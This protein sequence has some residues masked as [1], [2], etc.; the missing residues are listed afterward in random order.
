MRPVGPCVE[1]LQTKAGPILFQF[2][3]LSMSEVGG[4]QRFAERLHTFLD[5]LP[6]GPLYA[7]ELRNRE[8]FT[9]AYVEAL[10][11]AGAVHC[12]SVHPT[13]PPVGEQYHLA[14]AATSAALVVRWMLHPG[15]RYE[16]A[17]RRYE[18]F[19]QLVDEDPASRAA[20]AQLCLELASNTRPAVVIAN[21]KAEGSSPLT[22]QKL[23]ESLTRSL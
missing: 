11:S 13:M 6:R 16:A 1:G 17:R 21:N 9:P 20:I 15:Q 22:I 18:P 2:P 4:P 12:L 7:V 8:L 14:H 5:A 3:P 23:A 19:D 10:V